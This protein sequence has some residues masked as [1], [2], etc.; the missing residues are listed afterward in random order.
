MDK[1]ENLNFKEIFALAVQNQQKNN[2]QVAQDLYNEVLKIVPNH[3]GS[4]NNLGSAFKV[5]REY[6][7]AKKYYE[8]AI[9]IE[10][11]FTDAHNNLGA[12]YFE[13][14]EHQKAK[15]HYEKAITIDPNF[16]SAHSNL[17]I[18]F[19][20]LGEYQ[21]AKEHYEK[22]ITIDP[23]NLNAHNNLGILFKKLGEYQK[24]KEYFKKTIVLDPNNLNAHNNLGII[25]Q[26][27]G[28]P[29]KASE[30]YKKAIIIDPN[31]LNAHNNLGMLLKES[32]EGQKAKKYFEKAITIDPNYPEAHLNLGILL[33]DLG[34]Y[35]LGINSYRKAIKINP[36]YTEAHSNLGVILKELGDHQKAI[37]CFEKAITI[38]PNFANAHNNLGV[39][40]QNLGEHQKAIECFKKAIT[41]DPNLISSLENISGSIISTLNDFDKAI[42]S[43]YKVLKKQKE[44]LKFI[45]QSI[46][47]FRLKHDVQQAKYL[48]A[49]NYKIDGVDQ[50]QKVGDEILG[51][52]ENQNNENK[53]I[54]LTLDEADTLLPFYK[55]DFT[56]KPK[57]ISGSCINPNKNWQDV[58]DEYFNSSNQIMYIDDFLSD[59]ALIELREFCLISKVWNEEYNNNYLGAF[60]SGGFISPIHL[61]IAVELQQKLPKLFGP[62]EL[63]KFW[64]FKYD[65]TLGKGINIHADFALHNLNFWITPDEYNN[66]KNGGGLKVYDAPAPDHWTFQDYNSGKKN[67]YQFLKENDAKCT[68]IP[69]KHNRAVLFNSAYF[70]ETDEIDF[71]DE[72]EGRRIN[73]TYLFGSR[74]INNKR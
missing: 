41:I 71:K 5:L 39:T 10:P 73:N 9:E 18:L 67:V 68:N 48:I 56:Y 2:L 30:Y 49:K 63:G 64:G 52:Q 14:S 60:S 12:L 21:K 38:D 46:S 20:K 26:S 22:A 29:H 13:L 44:Q 7:K 17:G 6:Q 43:S 45:N 50:F 19:K 36:N 24:A 72:Y 33:I 53:E 65:S 15:E 62:H 28:E 69:H 3:L 40:L 61:Q 54:L 11:K 34:E 35:S 66:N 59:E 70:H 74:K 51:R 55:S 32:G 1:N 25:F 23:N 57:T 4:L 42:S 58:E 37:Q 31:N 27:L 8:K 47:F 16:V